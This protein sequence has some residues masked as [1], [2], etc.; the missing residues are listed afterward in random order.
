MC[1]G[2]FCKGYVKKITMEGGKAGLHVGC[3]NQRV[4]LLS[5]LWWVK[6]SSLWVTEQSGHFGEPMSRSLNVFGSN[7]QF[8][9]VQVGL[10]HGLN[11]GVDQ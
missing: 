7:C 8:L 4:D 9:N 5:H 6:Q 2:K 10:S 3:D 11:D 1:T